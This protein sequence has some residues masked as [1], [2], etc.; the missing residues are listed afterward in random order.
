MNSLPAGVAA[1]SCIRGSVRDL[2]RA[3]LSGVGSYMLGDFPGVLESF[4]GG[5]FRGKTRL[6]DP[7]CRMVMKK[8][9]MS[10]TQRVQ[11]LSQSAY[12]GPMGLFLEFQK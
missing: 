4:N 11:Q 12:I 3:I 9:V 6:D 8:N 10:G 5:C 7:T 2:Q 1:A